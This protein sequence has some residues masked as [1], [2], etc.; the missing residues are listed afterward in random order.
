M[1]GV[2][3]KSIRN[4]PGQTQ[5]GAAAPE[6]P[7]ALRGGTQGAGQSGSGAGRAWHGRWRAGGEGR[8]CRGAGRMPGK[9]ASINV[10]VA[11]CPSFS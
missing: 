11:A 2:G 1:P 10:L 5:R 8:R 9:L 4:D 3:G 7:G 6:S